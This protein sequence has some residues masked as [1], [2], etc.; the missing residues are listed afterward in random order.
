MR[1][2][3]EEQD[4]PAADHCCSYLEAA[5][6]EGGL[7]IPFYSVSPGYGPKKREPSDRDEQLP[8]P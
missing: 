2:L 5:D 8:V 6:Q 7:Q 3:G 4:L 1:A